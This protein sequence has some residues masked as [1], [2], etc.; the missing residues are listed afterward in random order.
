ML[1]GTPLEVRTATSAARYW[2]EHLD[3]GAVAGSLPT[4]VLSAAHGARR[5]DTRTAAVRARTRGGRWVTITAERV[6]PPS[7]ED[8]GDVG[9]ILQ[10]SRPAE[11]AQIVGA[12]HG[13][14]GRESEVVLLVASGHTNQEI[15]RLLGLSRYTVADHLKS[16]FTKLD[17]ASRGELTAKLFYDHYLP[18]AAAGS[19]AGADGWFL[20]D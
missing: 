13:L 19:A 12:A 3:D 16:V 7:G 10:P 18:R 11:I 14:T 6:S 15:A 20:P 8:E 9:L 2:L 17:V 1:S 4:P 5:S